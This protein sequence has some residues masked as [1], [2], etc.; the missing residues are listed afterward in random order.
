[1]QEIELQEIQV[2][3]PQEQI[4]HQQEETRFRRRRAAGNTPHPSCERDKF[5]NLLH[6]WHVPQSFRM[7]YLSGMTKASIE[8]FAILDFEASSL[9]QER[10]RPSR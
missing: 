6:G 10:R 2:R 1:M 5:R 3:H 4:G 8:N 7:D 9:S